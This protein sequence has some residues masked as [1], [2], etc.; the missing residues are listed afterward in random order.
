MKR[1]SIL[2]LILVF[3][4]FITIYVIYQMFFNKSPVI[5]YKEKEEWNETIILEAGEEFDYLKHIHASDGDGNDITKKV[6]Y[7]KMN[8]S[9]LGKHKVTY[10]V[11]DKNGK[12]DEFVLN[13]E[14]KDTKAPLITGNNSLAL[15]FGS[16]FNLTAES[17]HVQA[18][19][20]FEGVL[21]SKIEVEGTVNTKKA[22]DYPVKFKV[23]DSSGN[24]AVL[25]M[26]ITVKEKVQ[27]GNGYDGPEYYDGILNP[28]SIKPEIISNP[29]S[30]TAVV[31]KYHALPES[32]A[33]NDLVTITANCSRT[34]HLRKEAA[35]HWEAMQAAAKTDG[36]TL[37]A[38][39]GYRTKSYQSGLFYNYYNQSPRKAYYYSAVPRRSEHELG[40]ALDIGYSANFPE[41][42]YETATGKWLQNNAH[43]YGFVLRYPSD[44]VSI[45][46]YAYE[47]WHYRYV[48]IDTAKQLKAKNQTLEEYFNVK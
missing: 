45:T 7:K 16:D 12:S 24:E 48:G 23:K 6:T 26:T 38:F 36:I 5:T 10:S 13:V 33:P 1:K 47:S 19:D 30:I 41:N 2:S 46:Q 40:L 44:K 4:V 11:E 20:V 32:Y 22:G 3:I 25:E 39:S 14:I 21:T 34:V 9:E 18:T 37:V 35:E 27:T 8:E 29:S 42:F 43:L 15:D 31:N 28:F 17:A